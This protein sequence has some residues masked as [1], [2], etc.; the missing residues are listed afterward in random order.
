MV[1]KSIERIKNAIPEIIHVAMFYN[2]GI[3][4][5]TT[6]EQE[7]NIPKLGENLAKIL[8]NFR[9]LYELLNFES[10]EYKKVIIETEDISIIILK[11]GEES[12]IALFFKVEDIKEIKIS[13]IQRYLKRIEELIDMDKKELLL[14][15][16]LALESEIKTIESELSEKREKIE[17]LRIQLKGLTEGER[18]KGD[19]EREIIKEIENLENES[20]NIEQELTQKKSKIES[21]R[22]EIEQHSN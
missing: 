19:K 1:F 15:D 5:D 7:I 6:F 21:L 11:L 14:K 22:S 3:I 2:N 16:I 17:D 10:K 20:K 12:N 9:D 13:S 8:D 18:E 4:F